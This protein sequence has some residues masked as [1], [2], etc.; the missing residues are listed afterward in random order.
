M[1]DFVNCICQASTSSSQKWPQCRV[2]LETARQVVWGWGVGVRKVG[3]VQLGSAAAAAW[4][5]A[6]RTGAVCGCGQCRPTYKVQLALGGGG[7][8]EGVLWS[9]EGGCTL[10]NALARLLWSRCRARLQEEGREALCSTDP[11]L[12]T[13]WT[14]PQQSSVQL[15]WKFPKTT[16]IFPPL[17]GFIKPLSALQHQEK[18]IHPFGR[19]QGPQCFDL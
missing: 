12:C 6:Q 11:I 13:C 19:W 15:P 3:R 5:R 17:Q 2:H 18:K 4:A 9:A 16:Y 1:Y 8:G 10:H 14:F 7:E